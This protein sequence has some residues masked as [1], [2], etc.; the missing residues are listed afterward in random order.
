[1]NTDHLHCVLIAGLL[2]GQGGMATLDIGTGHMPFHLPPTGD[3]WIHINANAPEAGLFLQ[4]R[5][6]LPEN[7]VT[8]L[9]AEEIRPRYTKSGD[10]ALLFMRG[11]TMIPGPD[12]GDLASLRLWVTPRGI[13]SAGR[14]KSHVAGN[15]KKMLLRGEGPCTVSELIAAM[16]EVTNDALEDIL[17]ELDINL[18]TLEDNMGEAGG[19]RLGFAD[20]RRDIS[21]YRRHLSPQRDMLVQLGHA[22]HSWLD[23]DTRWQVQE[24]FD[25]TTRFIEEL[26]NLRER[27]EIISSDL[28]HAQS[29]RLNRNLYILSLITAIFMPLSFLTGLLGMNVEGIPGADHPYA[30]AFIIVLAF[31]ITGLQIFLFRRLRWI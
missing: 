6:G 12:P 16:L 20:I 24:A 26:D 21:Q 8:A 18:E 1:M 22:Q 14:R 9:L 2:D 15:L 31:G 28:A 7:A 13:V 4:D 27:T 25:R 17:Q 30:F 3:Y 10:N 23:T 5:L 19:P 11:I 29:T